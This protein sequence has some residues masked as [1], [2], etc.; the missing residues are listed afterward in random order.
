MTDP[1]VTDGGAATTPERPDRASSSRGVGR[2][3]LIGGIIAA[4]AVGVIVGGLIG[5]QVEKRRVEDDVAQAKETARTQG[6][7]TSVRSA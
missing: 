6:H 5:W 4:L 7:G 2:G 3:A 1:G